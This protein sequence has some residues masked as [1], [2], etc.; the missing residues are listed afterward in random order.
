MRIM[1]KKAEDFINSLDHTFK[2]EEARQVLW[3]LYMRMF[4][5][6]ISVKEAENWITD[7][8]NSLKRE[9]EE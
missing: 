2:T 5:Y 9:F 8:F 6:D 3:S 7:I 4:Y 1:E